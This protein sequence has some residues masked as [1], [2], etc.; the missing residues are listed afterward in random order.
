MEDTTKDRRKSL[1]RLIGIFFAVL[2][3]II[4]PISI[5]ITRTTLAFGAIYSAPIQGVFIFVGLITAIISS[6]VI[7]IIYALGW[8]L[9]LYKA[10]HT[11]VIYLLLAILFASLIAKLVNVFPSK[12]QM[13]FQEHKEEFE[14]QVELMKQGQTINHP[15]HFGVY[16]MG[17]YIADPSHAIVFSYWAEHFK[18]EYA[19][20]YAEKYSD[21]DYVITCSA[22]DGS[23]GIGEIYASLDTNW[24]LC[25]RIAT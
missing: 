19:Y 25:Y 9:G 11:K 6:I 12:E 24:Y 8:Q 14:H 21:L 13:Y 15:S 20:V 22:T 3:A 2:G 10:G 7:A 17:I 23:G 18:S 16:K 1:R 5:Y 4:I